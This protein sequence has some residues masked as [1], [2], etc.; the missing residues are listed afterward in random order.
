MAPS[1]MVDVRM[2]DFRV[3]DVRMEGVR[4][5]DADLQGRTYGVHILKEALYLEASKS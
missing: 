2:E 1:A 3:E 4:L 5:G